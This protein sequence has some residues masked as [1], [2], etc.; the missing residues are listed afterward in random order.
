M[1]GVFSHL[2]RPTGLLKDSPVFFP[3]LSKMV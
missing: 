1:Q 2:S 3:K